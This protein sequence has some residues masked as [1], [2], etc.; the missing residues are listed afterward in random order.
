MA[1]DLVYPLKRTT[2]AAEELRYSLRSVAKNLPHDNVVIAGGRPDWLSDRAIYL[3]PPRG[4]DRWLDADNNVLAAV[5]DPRVSDPF[6]LMNDDFF[7]VRSVTGVPELN[8]GTL[9]EVIPGQPENSYKEAMIRIRDI[10]V[11]EGYVDPLCFELHVP[12]VVSKAAVRAAIEFGAGRK[13]WMWR[14]ALGV[15]EG[16]QGETID[17]VKVYGWNDHLPPGPWASTNDKSFGY[18]YVGRK[19]RKMFSEPCEYEL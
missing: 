12:M 1:L 8:R 16:Y 5:N 13:R 15:F 3:D 4:E 6:V 18:G 17:D 9:D 7:V 19:L 10:L 2:G 14:T 11:D